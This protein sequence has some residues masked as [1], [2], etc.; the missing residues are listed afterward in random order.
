MPLEKFVKR[1][2]ISEP[3]PEEVIVPASEEVVASTPPPIIPERAEVHPGTE[4]P[5]PRENPNLQNVEPPPPP[6]AQLNVPV[7][8]DESEEDEEDDEGLAAKLEELQ[9]EL[10]ELKKTR[11]PAPVAATTP[12]PKTAKSEP[13]APQQSSF[14]STAAKMLAIPAAMMLAGPL[15]NAGAKMLTMSVLNSA[16]PMPSMTPPPVTLPPQQERPDMRGVPWTT[17][18]GREGFFP[19]QNTTP[20]SAASFPNVQPM[21]VRHP[22]IYANVLGR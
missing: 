2:K 1:V 20:G 11:A 17:I 3:N 21:S 12:D 14:F 5:C 13:A 22:E 10:E 4:G 9:K 7:S 8:D 19:G 6:Q 18:P 15:V 16:M